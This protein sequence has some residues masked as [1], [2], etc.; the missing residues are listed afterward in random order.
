MYRI[1]TCSADTYITN[2][3]I[4]N[5]FRAEDANVGRAGT[6]DIFK[7]YDENASGSVTGTIEVSRALL[8]FDLNPLWDLTGSI[9][10]INHSSF[11]CMLEMYDVYGGQTTPSSFKLIVFPLSKSFDEGIGRDIVNFS[12]LDSCNFV[13][14]S[15]IDDTTTLWEHTGAAKEGLL[16]STDLDIVSS[17]TLDAADGVVNIWKSQTFSKGDENLS[18]D[19]TTIISATLASQIP[20]Q[21]FRVSFS[22]T[23][24][25]DER[26]RFVKRF[27]SRHSTNVTKRPK[28]IVTYNDSTQDHHGVFFFDVTGSLFLN[29]FHR[30]T[31]SNIVSGTHARGIS[32]SNCMILKISS[33][34][35][36]SGSYFAKQL[37]ASQHQIG[38][39]FITGVYSATLSISEFESGS[40]REEIKSAGSATFTTVWSSIDDTIG[41][42]TGSLIVNMVKRTSFDNSPRR[43]FVNVTNLKSRYLSSEK[44]VLRVF[45]DDISRKIVATKTPIESISEIFTQMYY[46]VRDFETDDVMIPFD[47]ASKG[48]LLSTDNNG[49]Y[50]DFYMDSL[51]S[52]RTYVFDFLINDSDAD[53]VFSN[54]A[55]KFD[56]IK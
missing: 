2:K 54:V 31:P 53:L 33:G 51:P 43:L 56:I 52:G 4:N 55:A 3:I 41:Y 50:F 15:F 48:T 7:L 42:H 47:T 12:D 8:K 38:S 46:R 35:N 21:G 25:T 13:T 24:E 34:V 11:K 17:G 26:T 22:G 29:N 10:D 45:V 36:G 30:G 32:G 9:L 1:L 37:S 18:I 49:M 5:S 6:L 40:L 14:A 28:L 39:N 19:V 23:Q 16:G 27:A 20:N 44:V